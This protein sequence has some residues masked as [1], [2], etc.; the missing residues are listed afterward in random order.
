MSTSPSRHS[1]TRH[2]VQY[3]PSASHALTTTAYRPTLCSISTDNKTQGSIPMETDNVPTI[4]PDMVAV[5]H[6]ER[7]MPIARPTFTVS[8]PAPSQISQPNS[9]CSSLTPPSHHMSSSHDI[10][11]DIATQIE[12]VH[13]P[14]S[15]SPYSADEHDVDHDVDQHS[16]SHT[17]PGVPVVDA[18]VNLATG[19]VAVSAALE[20]LCR[21]TIKER[22]LMR[23]HDYIRAWLKQ[24]VHRLV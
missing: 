4:Y 23:N 19:R 20:P 1:T 15:T 5:T 24:F 13:H 8:L 10:N 2:N 12:A 9:S 18:L 16:A 21:D 3:T 22:M 17:L 14:P 11:N 7:S 6:N